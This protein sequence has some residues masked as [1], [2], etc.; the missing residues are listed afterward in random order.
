MTLILLSTILNLPENKNIPFI[1]EILFYLF[2]TYPV[3]NLE[4]KFPLKV[5]TLPILVVLCTS[6]HS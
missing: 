6:A 2:N 3:L 5:Y 1:G 4:S